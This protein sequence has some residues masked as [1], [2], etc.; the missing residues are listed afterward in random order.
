MK[1]VLAAIMASIAAL[2]IYGR[3]VDSPATTT[4]VFITLVL[5]GVLWWIHRTAVFPMPVL[6]GLAA[7][8]VGNMLGGVLLINGNTLYLTPVIGPLRYDKIFHAVA[9]GVAAWAS[10]HALG[11]WTG[12]SM[13]P[14]PRRFV[15]VLMAAGAGAVVEMVEFTGVNVF[16]E[17]NVGDYG[18]NMLDLVANL[19]GAVVIASVLGRSRVGTGR[20]HARITEP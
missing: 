7:V 10:W 13:R 5:V 17:T 2:F 12:G 11:R 18:N 4:Y 1:A 3:V 9:C 14:G 19:T 20:I 6:W 8:G 15:A 16:P